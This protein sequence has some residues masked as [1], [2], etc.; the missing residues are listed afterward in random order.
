MKYLLLGFCLNVYVDIWNKFTLSD[1]RLKINF[2]PTFKV[3]N[4]WRHTKLMIYNPL[5]RIYMW[6]HIHKF[7]DR[8]PVRHDSRVPK[9]GPNIDSPK[10]CRDI[11]KVRCEIKKWLINK[12]KEKANNKR[13]ETGFSRGQFHQR[14][15]S[16]FCA[17]RSQKCQ[18]DWQLNS[19]FCAFRICAQKLLAEL[20]EFVF[21]SFRW[22]G[23]GEKSC[24]CNIGKI[25]DS[26]WLILKI[27]AILNAFIARCAKK[28][29][30]Y[31]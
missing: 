22:K 8:R 21:I 4:K 29:L 24:F 25:F 11:W 26:P 2:L 23:T 6:G 9:F 18:K 31:T 3:I 19:I 10:I 20:L 5:C 1:F 13:I 16:S 30:P 7:F 28:L 17:C 27:F 15:T 12:T 14:A